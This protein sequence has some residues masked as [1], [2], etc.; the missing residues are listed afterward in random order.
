MSSI[1]LVRNGVQKAAYLGLLNT[2]SDWLY[3]G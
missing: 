2:F 3:G 1:D